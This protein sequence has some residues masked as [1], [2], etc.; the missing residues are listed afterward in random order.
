MSLRY[1]Q[2]IETGLAKFLENYRSL[3]NEIEMTKRL[4]EDLRH[5]WESQEQ[6]PSIG[7]ALG[8]AEV[9]LFRLERDLIA[10]QSAAALAGVKL[11]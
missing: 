4:R 2:Q 5:A 9:K 10:M 3:K 11:D 1:W 8:I 6:S 7:E